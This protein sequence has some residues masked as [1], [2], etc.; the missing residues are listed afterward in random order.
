MTAKTLFSCNIATA[1]LSLLVASK[2]VGGYGKS[3]SEL[4]VELFFTQ[5]I[6]TFCGSDPNSEI[7][8]HAN[9]F[10]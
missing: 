9:E 6:L 10:F 4:L 8:M 2:S 1:F 3:C 7:Y 5:V